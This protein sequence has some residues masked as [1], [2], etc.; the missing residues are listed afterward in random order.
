MID[1]DCLHLNVVLNYPADKYPDK[2]SRL[3]LFCQDCH[4]VLK[5]KS[6]GTY[7]AFWL[8]SGIATEIT[9]VSET[10]DEHFRRGK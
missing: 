5:I 3:E 1:D 9:G 2:P 6:D 7:E 8:F 10:T 4:A